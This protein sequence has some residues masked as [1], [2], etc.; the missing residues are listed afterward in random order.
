MQL[1][2]YQQDVI[3]KTITYWRG[4]GHNPLIVVPTGGGKNPIQGHLCRFLVGDHKRRGLLLSHRAELVTQTYE[5]IRK[6]MPHADV[7]IWS[8]THGQRRVGADI[9]IGTRD[10]VAGHIA[11]MGRLNFIGVDECH[12][13]STK[14]GTRY[15]KILEGA[16]ASYDRLELFGLSASP[17]RADQGLLTEGEGAYFDACPAEVGVRQLVD[18]AWLSPMVSGDVGAQ[19]D[20]SG[21]KTRNGEFVAEELELRAD[22][23]EVTMAVVKDVSAA[24]SSGRRMAMVFAC[25]VKHAMHLCEAMRAAGVT[26]EIVT[27]LTDKAQRAR[28]IA[29]YKAG[30]FRCLV[31]VD[32]LTTGFDAPGVDVLAMVRPTRSASLHVQIG[33]RGMRPVYACG[34]MPPDSTVEYRREQM[35]AGPKPRGCLYLDY[36]GNLARHG[37]FDDVN[38][39]PKSGG[40]GDAPVK[41]CPKCYRLN[42]TAKLICE[43]GHEFPAPE[44]KANARASRLP[45][46]GTRAER[47]GDI[48]IAYALHE[49]AG[50]APM[51]RVDYVSS[52]G[53]VASEWLCI[54][55]TGWLGERAWRWWAKCVGG[56]PYAT[57]AECLAHLKAHGQRPVAWIETARKGRYNE[58]TH[59][60]LA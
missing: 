32:V 36:G 44:K 15:R 21:L 6:I 26:S 42:A 5:A 24:L 1:R 28:L 53:K 56:E 20:M 35:A 22:I 12:L 37:P 30:A 34:M 40:G 39:R 51:V 19:I 16:R 11:Q 43:C 52:I 58:V 23:D 4:G 41:V 49:K 48:T 46:M 3:E 54:E 9:T 25:G 59:V 17:H 18:D 47:H 8:A 10:S 55:D 31:N 29:D 45:A 7:G 27:G 60:E 13:M 38:F 50:R 14:D 57:T 33:G 2:P